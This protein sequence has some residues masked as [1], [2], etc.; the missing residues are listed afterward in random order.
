MVT[1][2][3][4]V[5][6]Q[7]VRKQSHELKLHTHAKSLQSCLTLRNPM[8]CIPPGASVH[9]ILQS[10]ILEWAAISSSRGSSWPR[11]SKLCLL[12]L[13]HLQADS[14]PQAPPHLWVYYNLHRSTELQLKFGQ[15]ASRWRLVLF[16]TGSI[17][18][19]SVCV[20]GS[21]GKALLS[22]L[23]CRMFYLV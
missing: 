22:F 2:L 13:P 11:N 3:N 23:K 12:H 4:D 14:L 1:I 5:G 19:H 6:R 7:L 18:V 8:G 10:R 21:P 15:Q 9:G 16:Q 20:G 17:F